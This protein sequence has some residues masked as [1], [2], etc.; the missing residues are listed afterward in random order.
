MRIIYIYLTAGGRGG[1]R[2]GSF[3]ATYANLIFLLF[4][5][6]IFIYF[7]LPPAKQA[8]LVAAKKKKWTG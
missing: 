5:L 7:I 6:F 4:Y 8:H 2:E 1:G 3:D